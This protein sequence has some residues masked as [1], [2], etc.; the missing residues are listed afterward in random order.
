MERWN[1]D[2]QNVVVAMDGIL[3]INEGKP[4]RILGLKGEYVEYN[5]TDLLRDSEFYREL[6]HKKLVRHV[7]HLLDFDDA[8]D[9]HFRLAKETVDALPQ[10]MRRG[11]LEG[12]LYGLGLD[13][14]YGLFLLLRYLPKYRKEKRRRELE[15][16]LRVTSHRPIVPKS[17]DVIPVVSQP[18][19]T[20]T[21][22][23]EEPLAS[24][25]GSVH[26]NSPKPKMPREKRIVNDRELELLLERRI[27]DVLSDI[28]KPSYVFTIADAIVTNCHGHATRTLEEALKGPENMISYL[29]RNGW[30]LK[31]LDGIREWKVLA[32]DDS[33]DRFDKRDALA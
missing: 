5:V 24:L 11:V 16:R 9:A 8:I 18:V 26:N 28:V 15:E 1:I 32:Q 22:A 3:I 19:I 10:A 4:V 12:A 29:K 2:R 31:H 25:N 30:I 33:Q 21:R 14:F 17:V 23:I 7:K 13:V 27:I 6:F 20:V